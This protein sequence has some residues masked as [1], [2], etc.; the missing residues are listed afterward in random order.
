MKLSFAMTYEDAVRFMAKRP[1]SNDD[2]LRAAIATPGSY[3]ASRLD[4]YH[5]HRRIIAANL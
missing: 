4:W 3:G 5:R 1:P 2:L